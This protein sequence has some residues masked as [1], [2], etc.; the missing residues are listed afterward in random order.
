ME[1]LE[2]R[3]LRVEESPPDWTRLLA[4]PGS[5][6]SAWIGQRRRR[7]P[8]AIGNQL[9]GDRGS[10]D[11]GILGNIAGLGVGYGDVIHLQAAAHGPVEVH[12]GFGQIDLGAHLSAGGAGQYVLVLNNVEQG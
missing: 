2:D 10:R 1:A 8:I 9:A 3:L 7:L 11:E 12:F 6:A 4:I 5:G